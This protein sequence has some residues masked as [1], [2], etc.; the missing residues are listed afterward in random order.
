M[1]K[2][3]WLYLIKS[4][5][6]D[7]KVAF[8][9]AATIVDSTF[10]ENLLKKKKKKLYFCLPVFLVFAAHW[11]TSHFLKVTA[12]ICVNGM[13][14]IFLAMHII[15]LPTSALNAS[16]SE[17]ASLCFSC[18]EIETLHTNASAHIVDS[19]YGNMPFAN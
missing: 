4:I 9:W 13:Q 16:V 6:I 18:S 14:T 1:R 2:I 10:E 17:A 15:L 12:F 8:H 19:Q 7:L 3:Y 11:P 5:I